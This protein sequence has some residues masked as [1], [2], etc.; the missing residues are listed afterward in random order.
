MA[1]LDKKASEPKLSPRLA[2][3]ASA[4]GHRLGPKG[5][6]LSFQNSWGDP[7]WQ[8]PGAG[9]ARAWR[10][11]GR[12]CKHEKGKF[13]VQSRRMEF[14]LPL[15]EFHQGQNPKPDTNQQNPL[16]GLFSVPP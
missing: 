9:Q 7:L 10:A 15:V 2:F 6:A 3:Q 13:G 12:V 5:L 8:G 16:S 11:D 1:K 14:H 4:P